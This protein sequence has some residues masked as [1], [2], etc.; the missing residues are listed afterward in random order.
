MYRDK[1]ITTLGRYYESSVLKKRKLDNTQEVIIEWAKS[2]K[3]VLSEVLEVAE[4]FRIEIKP[5]NNQFVII[6]LEFK[7]LMYQRTK[8]QILVTEVS[9][10]G[11]YP[12]DSLIY[13]NSTDELDEHLQSVFGHQINAFAT[14]IS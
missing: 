5:E 11:N 9:A 3:E 12:L 1:F 14:K 13:I 8:D 10:D 6:H 7:Q 4:N 2:I